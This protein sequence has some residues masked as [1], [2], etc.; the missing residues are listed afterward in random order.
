[1][2]LQLQELTVLIGFKHIEHKCSPPLPWGNIIQSSQA[3]ISANDTKLNTI[4]RK[5]IKNFLCF[6]ILF[7]YKRF[8][9]LKSNELLSGFSSRNPDAKGRAFADFALNFDGS[10][11]NLHKFLHN[12][13]SHTRTSMTTCKGIFYLAERLKND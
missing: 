10:S 8:L 6:N 11:Q 13:K 5:D 4:S 1:M 2:L 12:M 7:I 9:S 3:K